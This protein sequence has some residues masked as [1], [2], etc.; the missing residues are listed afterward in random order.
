M[1]P[2]SRRIALGLGLLVGLARGASADERIDRLPSEYRAWFERDVVYIITERERDVFLDLET[3]EER[4]RFIEAFWRK[5]DPN[6]ATP[7]NEF[8]EEHYRRLD[9]AD[10]FLGRDTFRPGYRTDRGR[11]YILL[12]EPREIQRFEGY[13]QLVSSELWFYQG[14]VTLGIPSFFYLL[15]YKRDDIGEYR[16][17]DPVI[18]GPQA[19]LKGSQSLPTS[20]NREALRVLRQLS[21][22]LAQAS[23]SFDTSEPPDFATGRPSLGTQTMIARI[24]DSPK[25][26]IRADYADAYLKYGN[27]VS[28]DYS[29]NFVPSR[30]AFAV[31]AEPSGTPFVH[32]SMEIDPQNFTL[33]TDERR[34]RFYTTLDIS[35]EARHEE[36]TLVVANDKE[37]YVELTPGQMERVQAT[38]FAYQDDFPLLPGDYTVTAILKNR[39]VKQYTVAE[40]QVHVPSLDVDSP[41]LSGLVLA[42][43]T[44]LRDGARADELRTFQLGSLRILPAADNVFVLGETVRLVTQ[45]LG[46]TEGL[47]VTFEL[48]DGREVVKSEETTIDAKGVA[49]GSMELG[50]MTGGSFEVRARLLSLSGDVVSERS[51]PLTLSPRSAAARPGFVVRRGFDTRVPGALALVRG[52]QLWNLGRFDEATAAYEASVAVNNPQLPHARWKLA[53]AYLRNERPEEALA[54][55]EPLEPSFPETYEVVAGLGFSYYLM[56]DFVRAETYLSKARQIR[57]PDPTLLNALGESYH[58]LGDDERAKQTFEESLALDPG[59]DAIKQRLAESSGNREP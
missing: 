58:E 4:D 14:D 21:P 13:A 45:A 7:T 16:L 48:M 3:K 5:R 19:L 51:V 2:S 17:Y 34:S 30:S 36:G 57:P 12:G 18:D 55:L 37:V 40:R 25:R 10:R 59:Q 1:K 53:N 15:F 24:V 29:F 56:R 23:L 50:G 39:V 38:P 28:A 22:E 8:K 20:D 46:E 49:L 35:L 42:F 47:R 52:D 43:D 54:L 32:F 6:P 27:R 33:E 9:Y 26:A 41:L 44:E 31:L 11:F